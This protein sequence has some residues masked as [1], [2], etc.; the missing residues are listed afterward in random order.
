[1]NHLRF[2]RNARYWLA[3]FERMNII[4]NNDGIRRPS[5]GNSK[6]EQG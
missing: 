3:G 1:M 6:D 2:W 5:K 4:G